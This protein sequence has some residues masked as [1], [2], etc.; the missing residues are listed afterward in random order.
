MCKTVLRATGG[1]LELERVEVADPATA[2]A[3]ARDSV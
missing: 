1:D 2:K 3:F